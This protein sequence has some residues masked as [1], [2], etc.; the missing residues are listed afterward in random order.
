MNAKS[1]ADIYAFRVGT[2][3]DCNRVDC[4]DAA[5]FPHY[6]NFTIIDARGI[7]IWKDVDSRF[8]SVCQNE[9]SQFRQEIFRSGIKAKN[10]IYLHRDLTQYHYDL[11]DL[12]GVSAWYEEYILSQH[13]SRWPCGNS[14]EKSNARASKLDTER[15]F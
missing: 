10:Q 15:R 3:A 8:G 1:I 2:V 4:G 7:P 14:Q 13:V 11:N 6:S 5:A 12:A 9:M